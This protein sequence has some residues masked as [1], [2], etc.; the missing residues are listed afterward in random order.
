MLTGTWIINI[1]MTVSD[2]GQRY[3]NHKVSSHGGGNCAPTNVQTI[4]LLS[5]G[6]GKLVLVLQCAPIGKCK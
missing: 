1:D 5:V 6:T 3:M 4:K 2:A